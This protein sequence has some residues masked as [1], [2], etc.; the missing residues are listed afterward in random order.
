MQFIKLAGPFWTS[1]NKGVIRKQTIF[2][3]ILTV[4]QIAIA[5]LITEWSAALFDALEQRSMSGLIR[6]AGLL[7]LIF[8]ASMAVTGIHLTIKRHLQIAWRSWLSERVIGQWMHRGRH[9]QVTH[10]HSVEHDNPDARIAEDIRIATEDA[11]SL[12]HSLVYSLLLLISFTKILW[13]LSGVVHLDLGVINLPIPGYLVFIAIAYAAYASTLGWWIGKPLTLI[14]NARQS[15]EANFRFGLVKARENSLAIALI[16][17]EAN[18]KQRFHSL[19]QGV[20]EVFNRQTVAWKNI[21][22]FNSGYSVLS[23]A[24]PVLVT[25]PRYVL[26]SITLGALTQSVQ[27]FQH[28]VAALSWP[29]NSM[30]E[31]AQWRASV[32]R[33]LSLVKALDDLEQEMARPDKKRI[34]LEKPPYSAL[35]FHDLCISQLDGE[36]IVSGI[37]DEIKAGERVLVSGDT[38]T[39]AKLFKAIAGLWPWGCGRIELPDQESMFFMPPR[40]YLPDGTLRSAICYPAGPETFSDPAI[41]ELL[42]VVG[43][44]VFKEELDQSDSWEKALTR[45]QQQRLGLVRL[46]LV[47]PK[48]ILFQ[49]AFDSLDPEGEQKMLG[50]ISQYLP[51]AAMLTIMNQPTAEAYHQRL[52]VLPNGNSSSVGN[53]ETR[54]EP[55]I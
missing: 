18:E 44:E 55:G 4:L 33:V 32:E 42:E 46:L 23:L 45:E 52:L 31:I 37:D 34:A 27:A 14:T 39:A 20:A 41:Q 30:A 3:V 2:L 36:I 35:R 50:L 12:A 48:W 53:K 47:R 24:F 54:I 28:M 29:V 15:A 51:G 8:A 17:G 9:Y 38:A 13:T 22:L 16:H 6:Q 19:F 10:I 25:A 5:V 21:L 1:E 26:G 49:E 11:I 43:L 7:V 40:P